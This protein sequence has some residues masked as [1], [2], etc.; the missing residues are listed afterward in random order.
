MIGLIRN[1]SRNAIWLASANIKPSL[2]EAGL[3]SMTVCVK[4]LSGAGSNHDPVSVS[5]A[6]I[7]GW[8][9]SDI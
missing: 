8:Y 2:Q 5:Y 6:V 4:D 9:F 1:Q 3:T 7:G